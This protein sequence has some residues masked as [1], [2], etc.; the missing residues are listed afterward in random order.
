MSR[1][2]HI[3]K[4]LGI[5]S[6]S[7]EPGIVQRGM[8][9]ARGDTSKARQYPI[10]AWACYFAQCARRYEQNRLEKISYRYLGVN[11]LLV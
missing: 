8:H 2:T 5:S 6:V 9:I 4:K 1:S 10:G 7:P 3:A 11:G